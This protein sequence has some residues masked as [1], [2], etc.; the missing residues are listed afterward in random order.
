MTTYTTPSELAEE[1]RQTGRRYIQ[2]ADSE[3]QKG[4]L[5]QASEKAWG[6][7]TQHLKALAVL[8]GLPHESHRELRIAASHLVAETG[9]R[10]I[11]EL[12]AVGE[13]MHANFYEAWMS[14]EAVSA[15][16]ENMR[17]LI[18]IFESV[19]LPN[20]SS[21]P[22]LSKARLFFRDRGDDI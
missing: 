11:Y 2:Q 18:G 20:G 22:R 6:A 10:R 3:F 8:R 17:E 5:L 4:D 13:G 19:P 21:P 14:E 15:G 9:Q 16:V 1:Y 7:A 12:F